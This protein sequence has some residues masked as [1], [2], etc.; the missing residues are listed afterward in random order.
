MQQSAPTI[1]LPQY[2]NQQILASQ[3][4]DFELSLYDVQPASLGGAFNE[5]IYSAR[6]VSDN[7][8]S[9]VFREGDT[10]FN[11]KKS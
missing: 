5:F 10:I 2:V 7:P 1:K 3:I 11:T 8:R 9:N 6:L 4:R